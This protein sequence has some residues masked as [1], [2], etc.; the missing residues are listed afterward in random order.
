MYFSGMRFENFYYEEELLGL[1][2]RQKEL[3]FKPGDEMLYSKPTIYYW[4]HRQRVTGKSSNA[5]SR[6]YP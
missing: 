3:N 5:A 4:S 6:A 2:C 1:I